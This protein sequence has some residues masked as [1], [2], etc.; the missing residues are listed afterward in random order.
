MP[1]A[2]TESGVKWAFKGGSWL[3]TLD[4]TKA[5]YCPGLLRL[6]KPDW[7][8]GGQIPA[9]EVQQM[10]DWG[11]EHSEGRAAAATDLHSKTN[12]TVVRQIKKQHEQRRGLQPGLLGPF[13]QRA[14][15]DG[16][17]SRPG[18]TAAWLWLGEPSSPGLTCPCSPAVLDWSVQ[19]RNLAH[20]GRVLPSHRQKA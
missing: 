2:G 11:S 18:S 14:A 5:L 3:S 9:S 19:L 17:R 20:P 7:M 8:F 16:S 4:V 12:R 15:R 6:R 10:G 1:G 13:S